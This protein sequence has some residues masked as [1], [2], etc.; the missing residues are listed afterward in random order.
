M[1]ALLIVAATLSLASPGADTRSSSIVSPGNNALFASGAA[2]G[3]DAQPAS[4]ASPDS[5][6]RPISIDEAIA[7]AQQ[8][9]PAT[10]QAAGERR[11]TAAAVR[12]AYASFIPS[13][14]LSA[15]ATRADPSRDDE[16]NPWSK[17]TGIGAN[18]TLFEGGRR[19]LDLK[20]AQARA[21]AAEVNAISE[22][23]AV[24][25]S[26]KQQFYNVLAARESER[27]AQAQFEQA[28]QQLRT[29]LARVQMKTA[30][31]S[32]SLRAEI[33]VR[34]AR[35]AVT[36]AHNDL[37]D[38]VASLTRIVGSPTPVTAEPSSDSLGIAG[39]ALSADELRALAANAPAVRVAEQ[40]LASARAARK[41]AWTAYLPSLSAGYSR[42]G[43]GTSSGL[44]AT[45]DGMSYSGS[46]R[47]SASLPI[48]D[49]LQ[50]EGQ[51]VAGAVAEENAIAAL[52]DAR[53]AALENLT[54]YAGTF[55]SSGEHVE[56]QAATVAAAEED[57]RVQ[58]QRYA[59]GVSTIL[60][61]LTSQTQLDQARRDLIRARYDRRIAKAQL[62]A[63][64][65]RDL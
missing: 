51:V 26:V 6:A 65:G 25:L 35:L 41:S 10:V 57:L 47:L 33:Q 63:L 14:S 42:G 7:L 21:T 2:P 20:Q 64:V 62:E 55:R 39:I 36:D 27:A 29:A 34:N 11:T 53:L 37:D 9:A 28:D 49:Q 18:V 43:S 45:T 54:R 59:L 61:V 22:R 5:T 15:G 56:I 24:T 4:L 32:D 44:F 58:Q 3:A 40:S 48:F 52:R 8:N 16:G 46:F 38:A 12:S 50:R 17:S 1:L 19:I 60:D 30:T 23:Y 31:R 13:V